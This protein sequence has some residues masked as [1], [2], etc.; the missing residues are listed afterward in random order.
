MII[1]FRY[2]LSTF[3][4]NGTSSNV[5]SLTSYASFFAGV[6]YLDILWETVKIASIV[7]IL[8]LCVSYPLA[9]SMWR[10]KRETT[11][12][13]LAV[14]AFLPML[15]SSVVRAY[16]WQILL[17]DQGPVNYLLQLFHAT[18]DPAPLL[19]HT[20]GVVV[21]MVHMFLPFVVFPIYGAMRRIEPDL[22]EAAA[23]L[24]AGWLSAFG[25]ITLPLTVPGLIAGAEICFTLVL[26]SFVIPA[27]LGGG[28]VSFL[29]VTIYN[30][31][32][33]VNWPMASVESAVLLV[34]ALIAV[35]TFARLGRETG[36]R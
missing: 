23:D 10:A 30:D 34:V 13:A 36:A 18:S 28:R 25:R 29:P 16:G 19:F 24:G 21:A 31:T 3:E 15:V 17:N 7:T 35:T 33:A 1:F 12:I 26:G 9:Y 5:Y 20:A 14:V 8:S 2:S 27:L 11:Q 32:S 6:Y 4:P 22:G